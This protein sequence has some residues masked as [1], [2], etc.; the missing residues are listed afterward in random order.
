ME[1]KYCAI[2]GSS[3]LCWFVLFIGGI[4]ITTTPFF[5]NITDTNVSG[6][7]TRRYIPT[8]KDRKAVQEQYGESL[9]SLRIHEDYDIDAYSKQV[10]LHVKNRST[11]AWYSFLMIG[12]F[13][14]VTNV[15][16]LCLASS[17]LGMVGRLRNGASTAGA[18]IPFENEVIRAILGGLV[19]YLIFFSGAYTLFGFQF[20]PPSPEQ[21]TEVNQ[22]RLNYAKLA[23]LASLVSFIDGY[24][25]FVLARI[26]D[27]I[28]VLVGSHY[29]TDSTSQ[30]SAN[31]VQPQG[32]GQPAA[33]K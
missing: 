28:G 9:Q 15:G 19:V 26:I 30:G 16:I 2:G 10:Y 11:S 5:H 18:T 13:Y 6:N 24:R 31:S 20:S 1:W 25:P 7:D 29:A 17:L 3:L 33:G 8:D 12:L 4:S 14:T 22:A 23:M 21:V 32:A 27:R